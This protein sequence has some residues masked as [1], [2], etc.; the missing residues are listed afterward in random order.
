MHPMGNPTLHNSGHKRCARSIEQMALGG[1]AQ[2]LPMRRHDGRGK[3]SGWVYY[4]RLRFR[5]VLRGN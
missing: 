2:N 4:E 3:E 1:V 5:L